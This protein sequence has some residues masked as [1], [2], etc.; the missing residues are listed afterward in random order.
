VTGEVPARLC[1]PV[2]VKEDCFL[3][4]YDVLAKRSV[5]SLVNVGAEMDS[6]P[7]RRRAQIDTFLAALEREPEV[8]RVFM[9]DVLGA[10]RRALEH[11]QRINGLFADAILGAAVTDPIRRLTIIGG[12]N[13]AVVEFVEL[14]IGSRPTSRRS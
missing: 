7:L 4:A 13:N 8:G 1:G 9:V 6:G 10:G 11:R 5:R 2:V 14:A 3:T 12:L